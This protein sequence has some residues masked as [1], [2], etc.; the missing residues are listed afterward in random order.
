[1]RNTG[2]QSTTSMPESL[3]PKRTPAISAAP[4][5]LHVSAHWT[6]SYRRCT[7]CAL[8]RNGRAIT[9]ESFSD[10]GV[11]PP[12]DVT[13]SSTPTRAVSS[14]ESACSLELRSAPILCSLLVDHAAT[15]TSAVPTVSA[16]GP[17]AVVVTNRSFDC[18][19]QAQSSHMRPSVRIQCF[20]RSCAQ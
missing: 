20:D 14:P 15:R 8:H 4:V 16:L 2:W 13:R 9:Y 11:L 18:A 12:L 1:M 5:G 7:T 19:L 17:G 10:A 3:F 6:S